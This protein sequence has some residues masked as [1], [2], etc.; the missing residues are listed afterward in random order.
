MQTQRSWAQAVGSNQ[1]Q[2]NVSQ[3]K[4]YHT[5]DDR[6]THAQATGKNKNDSPKGQAPQVKNP[7]SEHMK[8]RGDTDHRNP[9]IVSLRFND[10]SFEKMTDIRKANFPERHNN[11]DAHLTIL[12]SLPRKLQTESDALLKRI[13]SETA[14]F[15]LSLGALRVR[16]KIIMLP[17]RSKR[18]DELV[19]DIQE[20][21]WHDLSDQDRQDFRGHVTLCNKHSE[22]ETARR[23]AQIEEAVKSR[24]SWNC[25]AVG[26][27]LWEYRGNKPWSLIS[28][29][30]FKGSA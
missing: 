13:C 14:P 10:Q 6:S 30:T 19:Y 17:V 16:P 12:H 21:F 25:R 3:V 23:Q 26:L 9:L 11:L 1:Q 5:V 18:L 4:T 2:G 22:E 7:Q 15:N 27:D 20:E 29:H 8:N 28:A 24:N